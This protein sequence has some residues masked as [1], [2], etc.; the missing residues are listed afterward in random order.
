M[1]TMTRQ[2]FRAWRQNAGKS[3][4]TDAQFEGRYQA[5][6]KRMKKPAAAKKTTVNN[7]PDG[8]AMEGTAVTAK[9]RHLYPASKFEV[10]EGANGTKWARPRTELTGIDPEYHGLIRTYD[11]DTEKGSGQIQR[12]YD[13]LGQKLTQQAQDS[14]ARVNSLADLA[15]R[16]VQSTFTSGGVTT[17]SGDVVAGSPQPAGVQGMD[18]DAQITR[19]RMLARNAAL[20]VNTAN[21]DAQQAPQT[22]ARLVS[23]FRGDRAKGRDELRQ[24]LLVRSQENAA[25]AQK[26]KLDWL[27]EQLGA[28]GD[29]AK[30]SSQE[31]IAAAKIESQERIAGNNAAV[32]AQKQ[33]ASAAAAAAKKKAA[34]T[35][36]Y[37]KLKNQ[38]LAKMKNFTTADGNDFLNQATFGGNVN[39]VKDPATGQ[40][41]GTFNTGAMSVGTMFRQAVAA[42]IKPMDV[43]RMMQASGVNWAGINGGAQ[44]LYAALKPYYKNDAGARAAVK[45]IVGYDPLQQGAKRSGVIGG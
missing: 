19:Q 9:N 2:Q 17:P 11:T 28:E 26:A 15:G 22:G 32:S 41:T 30:L 29:K 34:A 31:R 21:L 39:V 35:A 16:A 10:V 36:A 44:Y 33:Q 43:V 6:V 23:S 38:W 1:A 14:S 40:V 8:W 7:R 37:N 27:S 5:Y 12:V 20:D 25:A 42:G 18:L 24:S 13:A 45:S 3:A 4:L